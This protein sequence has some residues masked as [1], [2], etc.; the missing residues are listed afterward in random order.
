MPDPGVRRAGTSSPPP[1]GVVAIK[2]KD[3][4]EKRSDMLWVKV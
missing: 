4:K 3:P 1:Q 2:K